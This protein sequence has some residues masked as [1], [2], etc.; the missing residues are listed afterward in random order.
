MTDEIDFKS[1]VLDVRDII[2]RFEELESARETIADADGVTEDDKQTEHD[3]ACESAL[4]EWDATEEGAEYLLLKS[5]L[6]DLCGKGGDHRW[7]GDWYPVRL[8]HDSYFEE[9]AEEMAS[10]IGAINPKAAWPLNHID[11][12]AAANELKN[13]YSSFTFDGEEY[14][15]R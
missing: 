6:A 13:D 14:W 10:D 3:A 4:A 8:I 11:W 2:A 5:V 15:T 1:D 12:E 7:R 9:Y